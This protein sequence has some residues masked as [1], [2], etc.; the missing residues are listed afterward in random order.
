ML[1]LFACAPREAVSAPAPQESLPTTLDLRDQGIT[2]V[3]DLMKQTQLTKLD[4]RGNELSRERFDALKAALPDCEILWSVPIAG[5]RFD[6]DMTAL[7]LDIATDDLADLL[8]YFPALERVIISTPPDS[9]IAT[10]LMEQYPAIQFGWDI[11]IAG[12]TVA[13]D[14]TTLDLTGKTLDLAALKT[15][16]ERL[17]NLT[18]VTFGDESFALADQVSLAQ[19]FPDVQFIWNV[20]LLDDLNLRSDVAELD[21]RDYQVPDAAAFSDTLVLFPK[22]VRLDMCGT[23]PSDEEMAAMR[24]AIPRPSSSGIRISI[25]GQSVPTSRASVPDSAENSPTARAGM[26]AASSP[27]PASAAR[28]LRTSNIVLIWWRSMLGTAP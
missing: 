25:I 2:D 13:A 18:Q 12:E 26:T 14:T 10:A 20:Q 28:G 3:S 22:L 17:P 16:L 8:A 7:T 27:I 11:M 19:A 15:E 6:S 21:L 9:A 24:S 1:V 5:A 23:G 4:L